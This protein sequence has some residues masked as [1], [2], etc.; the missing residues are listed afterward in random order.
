MTNASD[1]TVEP[2]NSQVEAPLQEGQEQQTGV[3]EKEEAPVEKSVE[4]LAAMLKKKE[5]E[6]LN[7]YDKMLRI[8]AE[9]ENYKKRSERA[10][11]ESIKYANEPFMKALLPV[12][13]NLERALEHAKKDNADDRQSLIG[14]IEMVLKQFENI[15]D[16]FGVKSIEASGK[17]DPQ[18]H[19][20]VMVETNDELE[21]NTILSQLQ[22][23]Y[24]F[25]D[26]L[27]RP[28]M[29]VVSKRSCGA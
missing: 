29:V 12:I 16:R 26:R 2:Q 11:A 18:H 13:D 3:T 17:F 14:G 7:N 28:A 19:E 4:D 9:F 20:A 27:L 5:E 8:A 10:R 21:N 1:K 15:M 23:G 25:Q 22:K 24:I 6:A